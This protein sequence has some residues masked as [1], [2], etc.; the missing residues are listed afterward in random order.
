M[1][2]TETFFAP[3]KLNLFLHV[4]GRRDDGYHLLQS[5]FTLLDVGDTLQIKVREDGEINR[6]NDVDGIRAESDLAIR[7]AQALKKTALCHYGADISLTKVTPKGAGLGGGSSDAATVLL[8]LNRCWK[9]NFSNEK[10]REIG[11]TLGA[12]V[13]FF[14]FGQTAFVEGAGEKLSAIPIPA[15]WY[16]VLTPSIQVQPLLFLTIRI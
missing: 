10:L 4:I 7:A 16:V 11:L 13:P 12:D 14:L 3:A 15:W 2:T 9:L 1:K 8:A 6:V 5:I